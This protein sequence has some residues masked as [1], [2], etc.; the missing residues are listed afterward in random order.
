M[1]S[2]DI[3][4]ELQSEGQPQQTEDLGQ[5]MADTS[6][7]IIGTLPFQR[8]VTQIISED[9]RTAKDSRDRRDF[10]HTD[11]GEKLDFDKWLEELTRSESVV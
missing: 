3:K 11:K 4:D 2:R 5:P 6:F 10:G 8:S 9:F 7:Q 1:A